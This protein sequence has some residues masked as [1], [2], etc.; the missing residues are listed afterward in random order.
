MK[1]FWIPI[2]VVIIIAIAVAVF[3]K[4]TP[5][6]TIKIGV[7]VPLTGSA[8]EYGKN[9]E[10]GIELATKEINNNGG[11]DGRK[12]ELF[13]EDTKC[14][15]KESLTSF[16]KLV[17]VNDVSVLLGTA[18]SSEVLSIAPLLS[19]KKIPIISACA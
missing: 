9:A 17:E 13:V 2:I 5:K 6:G 4:P 14:D 18:C 1:K 11:V 10:N 16:N 7:L 15:S 12:L 3:Y 19:D 8:A